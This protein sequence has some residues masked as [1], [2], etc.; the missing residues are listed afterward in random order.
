[1]LFLNQDW[2]GCC[3][4]NEDGIVRTLVEFNAHLMTAWMICGSFA[5]GV[6]WLSPN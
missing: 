2:K 6:I 1:M 5:L 4:K 3:T